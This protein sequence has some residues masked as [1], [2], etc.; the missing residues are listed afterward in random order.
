MARMSSEVLEIQMKRSPL[1]SECMPGELWLS[2]A[3]FEVV[4]PHNSE[5]GGRKVSF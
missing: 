2:K 5:L 4:L 1:F 3:K